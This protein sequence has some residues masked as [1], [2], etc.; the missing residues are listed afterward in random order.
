MLFSKDMTKLHISVDGRPKFKVKKKSPWVYMSPSFPPVH[1]TAHG[2]RSIRLKQ[3]KLY[4]IKNVV[5]LNYNFFFFFYKN[6]R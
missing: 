6:T 3:W 4:R 2:Y 1:A 5:H